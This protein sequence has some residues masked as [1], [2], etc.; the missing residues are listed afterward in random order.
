LTV[1]YASGSEGKRHEQNEISSLHGARLLDET[2]DEKMEIW[3][4]AN[5]N[6]GY[7]PL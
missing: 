3:A 7:D 6:Q 5:E 4:G 1:R 2:R